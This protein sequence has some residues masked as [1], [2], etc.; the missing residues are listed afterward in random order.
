M[1]GRWQR[2]ESIWPAQPRGK[3]VE[4]WGRGGRAEGE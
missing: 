2:L 3:E 4:R 1:D